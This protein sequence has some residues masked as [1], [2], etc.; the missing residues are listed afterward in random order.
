MQRGRRQRRLPRPHIWAG[1]WPAN[2]SVVQRQSAA[3]DGS[4]VLS[5]VNSGEPIP[6]AALE[7]LFEP[8][9][10][11]AVRAHQQG[12]GLYIAAEI[13]RAHGW[14]L[15]VESSPEETRF[16]FRLPMTPEVFATAGPPSRE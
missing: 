2:R 16:T 7:R 9:E 14:T 10:R 5:V 6:P 3:A 12:L 8:F 11:G 4:L 15:E 13:A 1:P